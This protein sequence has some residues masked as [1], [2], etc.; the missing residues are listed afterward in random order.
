MY[1][2]IRK[3]KSNPVLYF[4]IVDYHRRLLGDDISVNI[5]QLMDLVG[6]EVVLKNYEKRIPDGCLT[7][8]KIRDFGFSKLFE[9]TEAE[10][11]GYPWVELAESIEKN[12][13]VVPVI[14]ERFVKGR[15]GYAYRMLE[16]KHRV[17]AA[18]MIK[19]FDP[20]RLVPC[21]MVEY[22]PKRTYECRHVPRGQHPKK[23]KDA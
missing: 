1:K 13:I 22:D 6:S 19:P 16:G 10:K 9:P 8:I 23:V 7:H 18:T 5:W 21:L 12:G 11:D 2:D 4:R 3:D 15:G 20:D 17:P 14:A